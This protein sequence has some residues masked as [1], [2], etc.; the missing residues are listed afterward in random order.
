MFFK[1]FD[2]MLT[3]IVSAITLMFDNFFNKTIR[4]FIDVDWKGSWENAKNIFSS[5]KDK[6]SEI[7]EGIKSIFTSL[8]NKISEIIGTI[9][10][11]LESFLG[12]VSDIVSK[13]VGSI[14]KAGS[15]SSQ[16]ND[17]VGSNGRSASPAMAAYSAQ[18]FAAL[19]NDLPHLAN[20]SVIRGGN[21][22]IAVLGEQPGGQVNIEA[23]LKTIEQAVE[24]VMSRNGYNRESVPVNINLNYDGE[25]FARVSISD[26]LSELGRQGYNVDV[27]GVT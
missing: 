4:S 14:D 23:P 5:F 26:I 8:K 19:T 24:N 27:L 7:V 6:I 21:P 2:D 13:V 12:T 17:K 11:V 15:A 18:S 16:L 1:S 22:F 10:D 20:G 9:K 3:S 25:T